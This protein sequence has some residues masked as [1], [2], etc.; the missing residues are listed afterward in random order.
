VWFII[1][2]ISENPVAS[3]FR[4]E[5]THFRPEDEVE[6]FLQNNGNNVPGCITSHSRRHDSQRK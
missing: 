3:I 2:D 4:V 5:E 6:R 1:P